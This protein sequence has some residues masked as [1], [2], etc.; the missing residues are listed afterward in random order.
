MTTVTFGQTVLEVTGEGFPVVMIHG[1]G[2]TSN[3]FQPQMQ[4]LSGYRVIRVDL[5]GS[6]RAP[7][8]RARVGKACTTCGRTPTGRRPTSRT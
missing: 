4:A 2:G 8:P 3:M 5:P 6:G 7:R 1:L